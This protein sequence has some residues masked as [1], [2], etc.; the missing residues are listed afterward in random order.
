MALAGEVGYARMSV[1]LLARRARVSQLMFHEYFEDLDECLLAAFEDALGRIAAVVLG[2]YEREDGWSE[3]VRAALTMLLAVIEHEPDA[4]RF[5]FEGSLRAGA[6]VLARR[7]E[8]IEQLKIAFEDGIA[9]AGGVDEREVNACSPLTA[10]GVVNGVLGVLHTRMLEQDGGPLSELV[11]PL[12]A[13]IVLPYLGR[14]TAARELSRPA[15][16]PFRSP[17]FV[18]MLGAA[19][20][21]NGAGAPAGVAATAFDTAGASNGRHGSANGSVDGLETRLG[22]RA[23][24]VLA[25]IA[26]ANGR[27][28][29]LSNLEIAGE[30]GIKDQ[31]QVSRLLKRLA[32][33]GLIENIGWGLGGPNAW[34][35]TVK[36]AEVCSAS[37][38]RRA[39]VDRYMPGSGGAERS[40]DVKDRFLAVFEQALGE[41]QAVVI[42]AYESERRPREQLRVGLGALLDFLDREPGAAR[43]LIVEALRAGRRVGERRARVLEGLAAVV[44]EAGMRAHDRGQGDEPPA[45]TGEGIVGGVFGVVY[46]RVA[47][48]GWGE[49]APRRVQANGSGSGVPARPAE[50]SLAELLGPLMAMIMLPYVGMKAARKEVS[51]PALRMRS[52]SEVAVGVCAAEMSG[53][54]KDLPTPITEL[55]V[56]TIMVIAEMNGRGIHPS[57]N[58][59]CWATGDTNKGQMSKLVSRLQGLDLIENTSQNGNGQGGAN[60]WRLT[61]C[62]RELERVIAQ[63]VAAAARVACNVPEAFRGRLD[64]R[65]VPVLRVIGEQP[66]LTGREVALRAGIEDPAQISKLLA[67]LEELGLAESVRDVHFNGTP[68]VWRLTASGEELDR[69]IGRETPAPPRSLA[70]DLMWESG[71]RLNDRAVSV[72]T[73]IGAEPGLSN[74]EIGVRVGISNENITS[75]LLARL[76]RRGL[77]ENTRNGGRVNVWR[78]TASG[79]R[80]ERAIREEGGQYAVDVILEQKEGPVEREVSGPL[81]SESTVQG[82]RGGA[83]NG[84]GTRWMMSS[85]SARL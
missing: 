66:W 56:C 42:P 59:L 34:R 77:M 79:E 21:F 43:V 4:G 73:V 61:V 13:M 54:L 51:A 60:A 14:E 30:A 11:S 50:Q 6:K 58:D 76:A 9:E 16:E 23:L 8:I 1:R 22:F 7:V 19:R 70:L 46:A 44:H 83:P 45:L 69:A 40:G 15:P 84:Y 10:K 37:C 26:E 63:E 65:A 49:G 53:A 31:G 35:L 25:V 28:S 18:G 38:R 29:C 75:Q 57:N 33:L 5:V 12:T 39:T 27:G 62:G 67:H 52:A 48:P 17:E 85:N 72:L 36:G 64:Y 74:N 68:N 2:A 71:G 47:A 80:L 32:G 55:T 20:S 81:A 41:A 24:R 78:L 82:M 3:R